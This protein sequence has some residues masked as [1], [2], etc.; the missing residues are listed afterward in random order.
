MRTG[1]GK[2]GKGRENEKGEGGMRRKGGE[3]WCQVAVSP[4]SQLVSGHMIHAPTHL[5]NLEVG[6]W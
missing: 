5:I 6:I 2:G 4:K 3:Y 1:G